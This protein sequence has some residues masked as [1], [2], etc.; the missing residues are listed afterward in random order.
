M[1]ILKADCVALQERLYKNQRAAVKVSTESKC[2]ICSSSLFSVKPN[3]GLVSF[4]CRHVY[5]QSCLR[6]SSQQS[7]SQQ[8]TSQ[9]QPQNPQQQTTSSQQPIDKQTEATEKYCIICQNTQTSKTRSQTL[10]SIPSS[11]ARKPP[12]PIQSKPQQQKS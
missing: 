12:Q 7:T 10:K 9:Q 1:E 4:F 5:H 2:A 3:N 6:L 11:P 8:S